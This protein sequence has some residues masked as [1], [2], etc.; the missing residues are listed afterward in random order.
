M[1]TQEDPDEEQESAKSQ[2]K[3][4]IVANLYFMANIIS[5]EGTEVID[6]EPK[7]SYDDLQKAY[8]ELLDDS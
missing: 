3:E 6:S 7:L 2:K 5:N 4:E 8:D 1:A